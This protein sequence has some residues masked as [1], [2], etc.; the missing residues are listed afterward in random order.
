ML[1]QRPPS[2]NSQQNT[3]THQQPAKRAVDPV[4]YRH[5][6]LTHGARRKAQGHH[7]EPGHMRTRDKSPVTDLHGHRRIGTYHLHKQAD[8]K[9]RRLRVQDIGQETLAQRGKIRQRCNG[10]LGQCSTGLGPDRTKGRDRR[11]PDE[12]LFRH[13]AVGGVAGVFITHAC[14]ASTGISRVKIAPCPAPSLC[15]VKLPPISCAA[16]AQ[17]CRPKP[18]PFLRVVKPCEKMLVKF[19]GAI[20]S[21]LSATVMRN[22]GPSVR[23][24]RS[25]ILGLRSTTPSNACL[26]LRIR[27]TRICSIRCR[28]SDSRGK[29]ATSLTTVTSWRASDPAFMRKASSINSWT[30]TASTTLTLPAW[31][32][33]AATM[34]LIW[35][36]PLVS[37][38]SSS[39]MPCCSAVTTTANLSRY[40]GSIFPFWSLVRKSLR[41]WTCSF[42]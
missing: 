4:T 14:A 37:C 9:N 13:H 2:G 38:P 12:D 33:W 39:M 25:V 30:G 19:S 35:L 17:L 34:L 10:T 3:K 1:R 7:T 27:F 29:S 15:T 20:P 32:C 21:P 24:A 16:S 6:P 28:S 5:Q 23:A 11:Q 41:S 40:S 18:C 8:D 31:D 26:A 22:T 42:I 36:M